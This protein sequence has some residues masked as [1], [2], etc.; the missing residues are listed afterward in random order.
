VY[1]NALKKPFQDG[2]YDWGTPH[3]TLSSFNA[4]HPYDYEKKMIRFGFRRAVFRPN[5]YKVLY[6]VTVSTDQHQTKGHALFGLVRGIVEKV[7]QKNWPNILV[8]ILVEVHTIP[9]FEIK[10]EQCLLWDEPPTHT[11][12]IVPHAFLHPNYIPLPVNAP[13]VA[14]IEISLDHVDFF[15]WD[16]LLRKKPTP[17]LPP[18]SVYKPRPATPLG[19]PVVYENTPPCVMNIVNS[20]PTGT[21]EQ[22]LKSVDVQEEETGESDH[23]SED[24][25]E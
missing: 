13:L 14:E 25:K 16:Y 11:T 18:P 22:A 10:W 21:G 3:Y 7:D 1:N 4:P 8:S 15:G 2:P 6:P 5:P 24:S 20:S 17:V 9:G 23:P 19:L 12:H